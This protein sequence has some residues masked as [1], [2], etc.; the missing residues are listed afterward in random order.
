MFVY[1]FFRCTNIRTC[2]LVYA[3]SGG[4]IIWEA[5]FGRFAFA[6]IL[7]MQHRRGVFWQQASSSRA[8]DEVMVCRHAIVC[9]FRLCPTLHRC[10]A[11]LAHSGC[12]AWMGAGRSSVTIACMSGVHVLFLHSCSFSAQNKPKGRF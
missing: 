1:T 4:M 2:M 12:P 8:Y 9:N 10:V 6:T 7:L 3:T 5:I 11:A